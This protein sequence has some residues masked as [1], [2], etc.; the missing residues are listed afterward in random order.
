MNN[1]QLIKDYKEKNYN[2]I[3][4]SVEKKFLFKKNS[5]KDNIFFWMFLK[6]FMNL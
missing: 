3:I 4:V 5:E 2:K 6:I 1:F